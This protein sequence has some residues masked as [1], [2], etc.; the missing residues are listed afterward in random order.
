MTAR[1]QPLIL[2]LL[3]TEPKGHKASERRIRFLLWLHIA[4]VFCSSL[5]GI[6]HTS[7]YLGLGVNL[8]YANIWH[9]TPNRHLPQR[10]LLLN[11]IILEHCL[12]QPVSYRNVG[13]WS[14]WLVTYID[15]LSYLSS[16]QA[17]FTS[18]RTK[19]AYPS[20]FNIQKYGGYSCLIIM[21][22]INKQT[23]RL[24]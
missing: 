7:I 24:R 15:S 14:W 17:H 13:R 10:T 6:G 20:T 12:W 9:R 23:K 22:Y 2:P 1:Y 3:H 19:G 8:K 16:P 21:V 18:L 5:F 4:R 11:T